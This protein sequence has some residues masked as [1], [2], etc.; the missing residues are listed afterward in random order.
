MNAATFLMLYAVTL[1]WLTPNVLTVA[2]APTMHPRLAL[3]GWLT[4]VGTAICAW[5]AAI[6]ILAVGAGHALITSTALTFC[7]ETLGITDAIHLPTSVAT[8]FTVA[9]LILTIVVAA[10]TARR[11]VRA[12]LSTQRSNQRH[13]EA[14]HM[15]GRPTQHEGVLS[16]EADKAAVYCVSGG[17]TRAIVTT[18]AALRL[19]D[20]DGLNAV[21][22]HEKAHLRGRHHLIVG[23]LSALAAA[24][25]RLPLMRAAAQSVPPL[26]EMCADDAAIREHGRTPLVTSLVLLSTGHRLPQGSLAAAGSAVAERVLRLTQPMPATAWRAYGYVCAA[27]ATC[28]GPT[29]A[30]FFCN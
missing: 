9:L 3:S 23:T 2:A 12:M 28:A 13:A 22:A 18:T 11:V 27:A 29:L 10:H 16:I 26:L 24:L 21:L 14:V 30:L 15:V 7:V 19:L 8:A 25:P 1:S 5:L 17:G 4:A 20:H 6:V